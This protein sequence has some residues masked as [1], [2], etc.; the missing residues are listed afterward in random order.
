MDVAHKINAEKGDP[1]PRSRRRRFT[2]SLG[3]LYEQRKRQDF[4]ELELETIGFSKCGLLPMIK[5]DSRRWALAP[6]FLSIQ[7]M[8]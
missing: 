2:R 7:Y 4:R 8:N 6:E 3:G 1:G 5:S